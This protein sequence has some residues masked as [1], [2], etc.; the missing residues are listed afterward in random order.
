MLTV[1]SDLHCPWAYVF[2][3][4]ALRPRAAFGQPPVAWRCGPLE[5]GQTR[6]RHP[7]GEVLSQEIPALTQLEPDHFA[8]PKRETWPCRPAAG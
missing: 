6:R 7:L 2:T 3:F 5:A 8:P 4:A 1:F